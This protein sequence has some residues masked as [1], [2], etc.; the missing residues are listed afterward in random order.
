VLAVALGLTLNI[1]GALH[2]YGLSM[3]MGQR[4]A[5][6]A[7]LLL[8]FIAAGW[9]LIASSPLR[10]TTPMNCEGYPGRAYRALAV[11]TPSIVRRILTLL[12]LLA[13]LATAIDFMVFLS[14]G[15]S[16]PWAFVFSVGAL[17]LL[18]ALIWPPAPGWVALGAVLLGGI[19]RV[20][21]YPYVPI[22]PARGDMLPLVQGALDNLLTGQS[23]YM[24]YHMPWDVPL[25]Y[26]PITWLAYLPPMLLGLDI[27]LTNVFAELVVAAS[28]VWLAVM[29][30]PTT[31]SGCSGLIVV[32]RGQPVLLLWAWIF[33]DP[34]ALHWSLTT[35][36]PVQLA[37]LCVTLA[38]LVAR[39]RWMSSSALGLCMAATLLA[40]VVVPFAVLSWLRSNG[41][42]Q[43]ILL[44]GLAGLVAALL[45][46]PFFLWSPQAFIY[47]V[48]RWF[49]TNDQFPRLRWDMD[50]TWARVVGFSGI[51]WRH[52]LVDIL[53]PLQALL[54]ASLA[55]LYWRWGASEHRLAPFVVAAFILFTVFNPILWPYLYSPAL[56]GALVAATAT[57]E[58]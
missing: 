40:A 44:V 53:K 19:I 56:V 10:P 38:F 6:G 30:R 1:T 57:H 13:W 52:G 46:L 21:S 35:T 15:P 22:E 58:S 28:L 37:L 47:G 11:L 9:L 17:A 50:N 3:L 48:W 55:G 27:R 42:R 18:L 31:E 20:A 8:L 32:W 34:T 16:L 39:R 49:N 7:A 51:F 2:V 23:P 14:P 43:T 24:I 41:L 45:V 25:T 4:L 5:A 36:A 29:L 12:M 26:L 54:L 33:L